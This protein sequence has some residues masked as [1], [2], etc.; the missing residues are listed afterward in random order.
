MLFRPLILHRK[1]LHFVSTI[2]WDDVSSIFVPKLHGI[3]TPQV[4]LLMNEYHVAHFSCPSHKNVRD[5][6]SQ[7]SDRKWRLLLRKINGL[8]NTQ[9]SNTLFLLFEE[10]AQK[11]TLIFVRRVGRTFCK[12]HLFL[13]ENCPKNGNV[14]SAQSRLLKREDARLI[15]GTRSGWA[16]FPSMHYV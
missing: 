12:K 4:Q 3:R 5:I 9:N 10:F 1:S 8:K 6:V 11:K 16:S 2:L 15:V 13:K 14:D 7:F